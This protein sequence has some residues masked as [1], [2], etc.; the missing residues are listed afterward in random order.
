MPKKV[1][2][3]DDDQALLTL[4]GTQLKNAGFDVTTAL[5]GEEALAK[6]RAS[7]PDVILLDIMLPG[8]HGY[9]VCQAI[10]ADKNLA[11]VKVIVISAKGYPADIKQSRNVGADDHLV[12]PLESKTLLSA[13]DRVF[14]GGNGDFKKP[15]LP[16]V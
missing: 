4:L 8:K 6:A 5:E 12:K 13:I 16:L 11:G 14:Q 10:R 1:L 3:V 7:K 9:A 2:V 15:A